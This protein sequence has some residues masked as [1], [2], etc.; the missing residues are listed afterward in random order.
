M[1][2]VARR[3]VGQSYT[4]SKQLA[5]WRMRRTEPPLVVFSMGKTG[6]T[7][8]ARAIHVATGDPVFQVF[9]LSPDRVAD[10][11]RRYRATEPPAPYPG[12]R[13][14]WESEYLLRRPPTA[15]APWTVI[16]TV[17]EPVAQ[18]VS[19]FFHASER[20]AYLDGDRSVAQL[21]DELVAG[22]WARPPVRWFDREFRSAFG[23]DVYEQPFDPA[24]GHAVIE[25][26]AVRVL[27]LRQESFAA[28][29]EALGGFLGE[30]LLGRRGPVP[31]PARNEASTKSY[32]GR[33]AEFVASARLP[34][35]VLDAAYGSRYARHFY[36]D[37]EREGFR[38]R[39]AAAGGASAASD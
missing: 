7:A 13:H 34:P 3:L 38:R 23:I 27:L 1:R 5:L 20:R 6:S 33:Y 16:T 39:W 15:S 22:D 30:V 31:V 21:V 17:R 36:A 37:R 25:T 26:P 11:E 14:L 19:A 28:A 12:A 2:S 4:A 24:T 32:G 8:I 35:E 18:A 9:R 10:A 29:P